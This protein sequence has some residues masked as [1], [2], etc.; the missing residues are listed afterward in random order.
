M[1]RRLH[2]TAILTL[3][4]PDAGGLGTSGLVAGASVVMERDVSLHC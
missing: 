3:A 2:W 1:L 4:R